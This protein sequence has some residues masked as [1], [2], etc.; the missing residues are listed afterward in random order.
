VGSIMAQTTL[1]YKDLVTR[2]G[3]AMAFDLLVIIEK[4]ANARDGLIEMDEETRLE[5][6]LVKLDKVA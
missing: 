2:Y 5:K 1:T 4:M 6:A 3:E